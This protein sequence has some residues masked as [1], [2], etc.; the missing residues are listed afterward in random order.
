MT[1]NIDQSLLD[2]L[3]DD[4]LAP[5]ERL[6]INTHLLQCS[7]CQARLA[8]IQR[9]KD[10]VSDM[11]APPMSSDFELGLQRK[12]ETAKAQEAASNVVSF[13]P[14]RK[15]IVNRYLAA[16]ASVTIAVT[17]LSW[18]TMQHTEQ[19]EWLALE[20]QP[21]MIEITTPVFSADDIQLASIRTV[22]DE[23][24]E[25]GFWTDNETDSFDQF[26]QVDNGYQ[27]FSCGSTV[28]ERGC[29]LG[30]GKLVAALTVKS[31]I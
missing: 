29:T 23:E 13:K 26:T 16:A 10:L 5:R 18:L 22:G 27:A 11:Q 8:L 25:Q 1:C 24:Q 2:G 31:A 19:D 3:I 6:E 21:M 15:S 12:I 20:E 17:G 30:P 28:G 9:T 4:Q 14:E 7:E